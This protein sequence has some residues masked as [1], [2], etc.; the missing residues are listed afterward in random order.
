MAKWTGK[1]PAWV[2]TPLST[3]MGFRI[4]P[5]QVYDD[6]DEQVAA[7][8]EATTENGKCWGF[9]KITPGRAR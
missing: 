5:G 9:D 8:I 6:S 3:N 2:N 4:V 1:T 7:A